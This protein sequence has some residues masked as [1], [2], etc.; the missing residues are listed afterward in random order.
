LDEASQSEVQDYL[1]RYSGTDQEDRL[2]AEWLLQLG[3]NRD[4]DT[5]GR[6]YPLYRMN[7][8]K[9]VRCYALLGGLP[10]PAMPMSA[11]ALEP[12]WWATERSRRRVRRSGC[13]TGQRQKAQRAQRMGPGTRLGMENDRLRV[14]TQ[15]VAALD[16][17]YVK[18]VNAIYSTPG[19]VPE[20]QSHRAAVHRRA[21][22]YRS[23]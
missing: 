22:W 15:A 9:S 13:A 14:A 20:R 12:V 2:R 6:E 21:N 16:S 3:R 10:A 19:Q 17:D 7:D 23:H 8:D 11:G 18:T 5:F 1:N 4:W